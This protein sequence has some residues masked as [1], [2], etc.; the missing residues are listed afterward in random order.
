M[1]LIEVDAAKCKKDGL[2]VVVCPSKVLEAGDD[3]GPVLANPELCNDCGHCLAVCPH[4]ALTHERL[5]G[6]TAGPALRH[7]PAP[8]VVDG[9]LRSRRS[10]RCYADKPVPR[11]TLV[12]LLEVAR[13][14]PT[15]SNA[16]EIRWIVTADPDRVRSLAGLTAAWFAGLPQLRAVHKK[17]LAL[18]ERGVDTFLRGAPALALVHTAGDAPFGAAD[19]GIALTFLELAAVSRGLGTCWAGLLTMAATAD[20]ALRRALGLAEDQKLHGG[21]MLGYPGLRYAGVPRRN[22]AVVSWL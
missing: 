15:A 2:C 18:W 21:L 4:G 5:P 16:Q 20:A 17:Y 13:F 8:D 1:S 7:F 9:L 12:E 19:S 10:I 6:G 3:G 14:A 22:P 11:A